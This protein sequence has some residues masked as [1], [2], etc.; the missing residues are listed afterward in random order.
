MKKCDFCGKMIDGNTDY[1]LFCGQKQSQI[2]ETEKT[3][4]ETKE[5][6]SENNVGFGYKLKHDKKTQWIVAGAILVIGI[7]MLVGIPFLIQSSNSSSH[8]KSQISESSLDTA[9]PDNSVNKNGYYYF[10]SDMETAIQRYRTIVNQK[11]DSTLENTFDN[12]AFDKFSEV[13]RYSLFELDP[14]SEFNY[15]YYNKRTSVSLYVNDDKKIPAFSY[16]YTSAVTSSLNYTEEQQYA[17][18]YIKPTMWLYSLS[19]DL[20]YE[21]ALDIYT[22][23]FNL[24]LDAVKSAI[25]G[26]EQKVAHYYNGYTMLVNGTASM[27]SVTI[28]KTDNDFIQ[29]H[30]IKAGEQPIFKP[31]GSDNSGDNKTDK[32]TSEKTTVSADNELG[33]EFDFTVD[34]FASAL[35]NSIVELNLDYKVSVSDYKPMEFSDEKEK[36]GNKFNID[37]RGYEFNNHNLTVFVDNKTD[38]LFQIE[39]FDK[40]ILLG[41]IKTI[42]P[43]FTKNEVENCYKQMTYS[44]TV[45]TNDDSSITIKYLFQDNICYEY[46]FTHTFFFRIF[47]SSKDN[48]DKYLQTVSSKHKKV[49]IDTTAETKSNSDLDYTVEDFG[50]FYADVPK[51]WVYEV[52]NGGISFYEK[53]NHSHGETGSTGYLCRI[54]G[55]SPENSD[56]LSPNS[57]YLGNA[58]DLDYYIEFPM[59]IGMIEDKT[60]SEKMQTAHSQVEGFV[61][62]IIF[63]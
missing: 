62:S 10:D 13:N 3:D 1:C 58:S 24:H 14:V 31:I 63:K 52:E 4:I 23:L 41:V 32:T 21:Q 7:V 54:V 16:S 47:S 49:D 48:Y 60:A 29:R 51:N 53:Y 43:S 38:N 2:S 59:G 45:F 46:I 26:N 8:T 57:E 5:S 11:D 44:N 33:Y 9:K 28:L 6:V 18:L 22:N 34:S 61:E 36:A 40:D 37:Y 39:I 15:A 17:L 20:S 50:H 55:I 30:N 27:E 35:K 19:N 56:T 12:I 25:N 42:Y